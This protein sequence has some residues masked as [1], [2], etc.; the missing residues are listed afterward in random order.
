MNEKKG[1]AFVM[2][3]LLLCILLIFKRLTGEK[4]H[5]ILGFIFLGI[6]ILH[7]CR[8]ICKLKHKKISVKLTD[9]IMMIA[10]LIVL[11]SGVLLHPFKGIFVIKVIHKISSLFFILGMIV[12]VIQHKKL[13]RD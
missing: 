12:H 13:E 11:I 7:V 2:V 4:I 3:T 1:K 6:T 5:M 8:H 10:L 9:W